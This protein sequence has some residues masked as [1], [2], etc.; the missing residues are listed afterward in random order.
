MHSSSS[1]WWI[2]PGV[3]L[4]LGVIL[5]S[6]A[7]WGSAQ[8]NPAGKEISKATIFRVRAV[9]ISSGLFLTIISALLAFGLMKR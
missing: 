4:V 8:H 7:W 3:S 5:I 9:L 6:Q 1:L 2:G